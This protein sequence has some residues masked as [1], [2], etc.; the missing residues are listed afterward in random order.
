MNHKIFNVLSIGFLLT[1]FEISETYCQ[2]N[3][4]FIDNIELTYTLDSA[5]HFSGGKLAYNQFLMQNLQYP[6]EA[7]INNIQGKVYVTFIVLASGKLINIKTSEGANPH[8]AKEAIRL[9]QIMPDWV[10]AY[11]KGNPVNSQTN[12]P[13]SFKNLGLIK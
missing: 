10:P 7:Q 4:P 5:A 3:T 9:I 11:F 8:L 1:I 2:N 13:I 6:F 12:L